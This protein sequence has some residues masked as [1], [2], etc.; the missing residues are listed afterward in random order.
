MLVPLLKCS[1]VAHCDDS[2]L[3]L[4]WRKKENSPLSVVTGVKGHI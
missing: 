1:H 3:L 2:V 4:S